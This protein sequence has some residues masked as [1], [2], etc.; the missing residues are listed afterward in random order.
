MKHT[1]LGESWNREGTYKMNK[2]IT[3]GIETIIQYTCSVRASDY[4]VLYTAG[5]VVIVTVMATAM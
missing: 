2:K 1:Y 3:N 5:V 4:Q